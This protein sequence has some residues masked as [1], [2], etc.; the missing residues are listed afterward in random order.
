MFLQGDEHHYS[1]RVLS[2]LRTG[3]QRFRC[4]VD[5][6]ALRRQF[7]VCKPARCSGGEKRGFFEG[8][9]RRKEFMKAAGLLS[10]RV[11]SVEAIRLDSKYMLVKTVWNMR[12]RTNN[13]DE[14]A[15]KTSA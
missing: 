9:P 3:Q 4:P 6:E 14:V 1:R 7:H 5:F 15:N 2:C 13:G 12:I 10:S 11:D 8:L